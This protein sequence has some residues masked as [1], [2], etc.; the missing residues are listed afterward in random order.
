M[1]I[2]PEA[3]KFSFRIPITHAKAIHFEKARRKKAMVF[4]ENIACR[5]IASR[6]KGDQAEFDLIKEIEFGDLF[7]Y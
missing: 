4:C 7:D 6:I 3:K 2:D 5:V 1:I